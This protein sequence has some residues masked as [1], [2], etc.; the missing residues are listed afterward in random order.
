M[1]TAGPGGAIS[2]GEIIEI[3]NKK[4]NLDDIQDNDLELLINYTN[5]LLEKHIEA[6]EN[7]PESKKKVFIFSDKCKEI[8]DANNRLKNNLLPQISRKSEQYKTL[9]KKLLVTYITKLVMKFQYLIL[10]HTM[11]AVVI[12]RKQLLFC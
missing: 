1:A 8:I 5:E 11:N 9:L 2:C 6:I 10:K 7:N 3:Y 4:I 12:M